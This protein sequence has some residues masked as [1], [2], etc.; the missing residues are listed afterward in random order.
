M[1]LTYFILVFVASIN[2]FGLTKEECRN[3]LIELINSNNEL[4]QL[5]GSE[6][7]DFYLNPKLHINQYKTLAND[8][9]LNSCINQ[10]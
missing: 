8:K 2:T 1:K 5:S 6:Q 3:H 10:K 4:N 7:V 9:T